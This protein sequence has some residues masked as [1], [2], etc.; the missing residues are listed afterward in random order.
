MSL[1][2]VGAT[3]CCC[4]LLVPLPALAEG[5][6]VVLTAGGDVDDEDGYR[7]DLGLAWL[8][9]QRTTITVLG[10]R[11]DTSAGFNDFQSSTVSAAVDHS[12]GTL[13]FAVD[14]RWWGDP[15]V[16]DSLALG[17]ALH[18]DF[19][20]WRIAARAEMRQSDFEP[21]DF[22][23]VVPVRTPTG[24]VLV[25]ISGTADCDLD[26]RA[27]GLGVGRSGGSWSFSLGGTSYDY[28]ATSCATSNV[29]V[30]PQ[31]GDLPRISREIFRRIAARVVDSTARLIGTRLTRENGFLESTVNAG[32]SFTA[33]EWTW[34][35][36]YFHDREEFIG[37][38]SDTLVG[39]VTLPVGGRADLELRLGATDTDLTGTVGFAG[40]TFY[41]YLGGGE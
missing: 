18:A 20:Q 41:V 11:A 6:A 2:E 13:G 24:I 30:P 40:L 12:F 16:V 22:N 25:P 23:T 35:A 19:A 3:I 28:D 1:S 29:V 21:F 10:S 32:L 33:G 15:D 14:A 38:E 37:L 5:Q 8:P 26:N 36:D 31:I 27:Y 17:A 4:A 9:S 34:A 7:L 39:S